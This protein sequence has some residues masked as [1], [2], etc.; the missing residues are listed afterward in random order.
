M[1]TIAI[2]SLENRLKQNDKEN[3]RLKAVFRRFPLAKIVNGLFATSELNSSEK[4]KFQVESKIFG[5]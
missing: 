3:G 2:T 5:N 4:A 1:T